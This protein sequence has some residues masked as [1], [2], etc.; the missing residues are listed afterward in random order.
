[1]MKNDQELIALFLAR[2]E[3]AISDSEAK[4]GRYCYRLASNILKNDE[5]AEECLSTTW[6]KVWNAIP[7]TIPMSLKHF[8]S[9]ITRNTAFHMYRTSRAAKR[10]GGNMDA[11]LDELEECIA[12]SKN[13]EEAYLAKELGETINAFVRGL[14]QPER[15]VFV[16]RYYFAD[17]AKVIAGE[18]GLTES[19]VNVILHRTRKKLQ[20]VLI[21]EGMYHE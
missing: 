4:Y 11:V 20:K 16:R 9:T 15:S 1:M 18:Y 10:G 7:P 13:T 6:M 5:D 3:E 2:K 21:Q 17:P 14:K 12:D 8:L 19:Y